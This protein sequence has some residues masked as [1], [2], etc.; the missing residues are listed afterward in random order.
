MPLS[1]K[2]TSAASA[3]IRAVM[4]TQPPSRPYLMALSSRL[5]QTWAIRVA[6]TRTGSGFSVASLTAILRSSATYS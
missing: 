4:V 3:V 5:A 1:A 6:S 2:I